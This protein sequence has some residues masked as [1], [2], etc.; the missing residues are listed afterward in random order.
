MNFPTLEF[1]V[2][3]DQQQVTE[4][5][6]AIIHTIIWHRTVGEVRPRDEKCRFLDLVYVRVDNDK[7]MQEVDR[8]AADFAKAVRQG[9]HKTGQLKVAFFQKRTR[10]FK[11]EKNVWEKWLIDF[12][13]VERSDDKRAVF[14]ASVR[15]LLSSIALAVMR[16]DSHVPLDV[17]NAEYV[18]KSISER[19]FWWEVSFDVGQAGSSGID[20]IR[21]VI[22][23]VFSSTNA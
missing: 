8:A 2:S 10:Y 14:S 21:R 4:A 23:S 18:D 20:S 7:L 12:K 15:E 11:Q 5:A 3:V 17:E 1:P 22:D 6:V 13:I 19:P 9:N 16:K